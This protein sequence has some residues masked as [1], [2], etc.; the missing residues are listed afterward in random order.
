MLKITVTEEIE[1][2]KLV[3][4]VHLKGQLTFVEAKVLTP[5]GPEAEAEH[6]EEFVVDLEHLTNLDSGALAALVALYHRL[7][8]HGIKFFLI[9]RP[10]KVQEVLRITKLCNVLLE[11]T[12]E[13]KKI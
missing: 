8:A 9:N 2:D 4:T 6:V 10:P 5:L 3:R 1:E 11:R 7:V 13:N 12:R